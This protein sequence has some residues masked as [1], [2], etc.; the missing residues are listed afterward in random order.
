MPAEQGA[1]LRRSE[2]SS[3]AET[4]GGRLDVPQSVGIIREAASFLPSKAVHQSDLFAKG[5]SDPSKKL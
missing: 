2:V 5:A 3:C 1:N 4:A